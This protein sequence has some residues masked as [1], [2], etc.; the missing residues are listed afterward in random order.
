MQ[1]VLYGGH[2]GNSWDANVSSWC[3]KKHTHHSLFC[4]MTKSNSFCKNRQVG[5]KGTKMQFF[6]LLCQMFLMIFL[7]INYLVHFSW[8]VGF[9]LRAPC[10]LEPVGLCSWT[11]ILPVLGG[12]ANC[13]M[14]QPR[15]CQMWKK[16]DEGLW[17]LFE[18]FFLMKNALRKRILLGKSDLKPFKGINIKT[19]TK[20]SQVLNFPK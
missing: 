15:N 19:K 7:L 5:M 2:L 10:F 14:C 18:A 3:S 4:N 20:N 16:R 1:K 6:S 11:L 9:V 13:L 8:H 12:M 17:D